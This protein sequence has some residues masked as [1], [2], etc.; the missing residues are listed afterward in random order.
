MCFPTVMDFQSVGDFLIVTSGIF[1]ILLLFP[2]YCYFSVVRKGKGAYNRQIVGAYNILLNKI[3]VGKQI[4]VGKHI[5]D[6]KTWIKTLRLL[7][8]EHVR[9]ETITVG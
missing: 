9:W 3:T 4:T 8:T 5:K 2:Y 6:W 7:T 1:E